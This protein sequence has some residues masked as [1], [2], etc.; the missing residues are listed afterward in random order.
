MTTKDAARDMNGIRLALGKPYPQCLLVDE[1]LDAATPF[2][3]SVY[4]PR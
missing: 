4:V 2:E 3:G 1:T